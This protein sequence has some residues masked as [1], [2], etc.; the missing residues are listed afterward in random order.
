MRKEDKYYQAV[1]ELYR[2][3][4]DIYPPELTD[5]W[6]TGHSLGGALA[7]LLGRTF[8]LP[9]VAF[10]AP[11]EMLATRRLHLPSPPGLTTYG[12]HLALWKHC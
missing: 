10:E 1:L 7:S 8:G 12:K 6:V 4:T 3:V 2:N 9:A 11:G 5:I